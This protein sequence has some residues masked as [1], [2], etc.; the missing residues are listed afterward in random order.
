VDSTPSI[1]YGVVYV[2][3]LDGNVYAIGVHPTEAPVFAGLSPP[4]GAWGEDPYIEIT[5]AYFTSGTT[6]TFSKDGSADMFLQVITAMPTAIT[7]SIVI[8]PGTATGPWDIRITSPYGEAGAPGAFTVVE[9]PAMEIE[10]RCP[11]DLVVEDSVGCVITKASNE[12]P[13][14]AYWEEDLD[15]DGSPDARVVILDPSGDYRISMV[16]KPDADPAD[17]YTL[18]VTNGEGV[19]VTLAEEVPVSNIYRGPY[20]I[21]V[22]ET[23]D[24]ERIAYSW[25][26]YLSPFSTGNKPT[27]FKK[28]VVIPVKF[29]LTGESSGITDAIAQ[30]YYAQ[31]APEPTY[32]PATPVHGTDNQFRY[33]PILDQYIFNWNTGGLSAGTYL[34]K[35][36]MGDGVVRTV[37]IILG[38]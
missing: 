3:S 23:G 13:D 19:T 33:D 25:S 18:T 31:V 14:A 27:T 35:T 34:L 36:E 9:A 12:I 20:R 17:T 10:A 21:Q 38:K 15:N 37:T 5:G 28:G 8:P 24:V 22:T 6:V 11:V 1:A 16:Q 26:G 2:G 32:Y 29:R 4:V 7:G 30:L